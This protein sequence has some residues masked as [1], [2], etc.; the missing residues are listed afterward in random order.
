MS[1]MGP[2]HLSSWWKKIFFQIFFKFF[3]ELVPSRDEFLFANSVVFVGVNT[4]KCVVIL[5]IGQLKIILKIHAQREEKISEFI[6]A[7]VVIVTFSCLS[8]CWKITK[9]HPTVYSDAL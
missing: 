4:S 1:M 8:R 3:F 9:I 6:F 7:D 2:T 5:K